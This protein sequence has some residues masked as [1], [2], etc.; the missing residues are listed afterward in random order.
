VVEFEWLEDSLRAKLCKYPFDYALNQFY[1]CQRQPI[2]HYKKMKNKLENYLSKEVIDKYEH[3]ILEDTIVYLGENV[4]P[5][6]AVLLKKIIMVYGGFYLEVHSPIVTHI[7]TEPVTEQEYGELKIFG[8]LVHVLRVEWLIDTI[9]LNKRMKEEDYFIRSFKSRI[10]SSLHFEDRTINNNNS[11]SLHSQPSLPAFP[12]RKSISMTAHLQ[13]KP[14]E[15]KVVRKYESAIFNGYSFYIESTQKKDSELS[16][17]ALKISKN[18]GQVYPSRIHIVDG[19]CFYVLK[20]CPERRKLVERLREDTKADPKKG[21]K[22]Q[23]QPISHRWVS[24]CVARTEF[25]DYSKV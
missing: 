6:L 19:F 24:E 7:L 9:Y 13:L 8:T 5:D 17:I 20:D 18:G 16:D 4:H 1:I 14:K 3:R 21:G 10:N 2:E 11:L 22:V 12:A 15:V 25:I 23:I